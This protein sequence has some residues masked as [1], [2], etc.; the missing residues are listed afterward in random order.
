MVVCDNCFNP[1]CLRTN[2]L[3]VACSCV[4][5]PTGIIRDDLATGATW[6]S[7]IQALPQTSTG[8]SVSLID[9][10]RGHQ[11]AGTTVPALNAAAITLYNGGADLGTGGAWYSAV[12]GTDGGALASMLSLFKHYPQERD[13]IENHLQGLALSATQAATRTQ[14]E[15]ANKY[16][17]AF[18]DKL[19]HQTKELP[20]TATEFEDRRLPKSRLYVLCAKGRMVTKL[21]A[22]QAGA[23][24]GKFDATLG[25]N[26]T[27]FEKL[28]AVTD[29]NMLHNI[30]TDYRAC[31]IQIGKNG[32]TVAWEPFWSSIH[33]VLTASMD[34]SMTHELIYE[35]LVKMDEQRIDPL[36]FM[37]KKWST[38]YTTFML[39]FGSSSRENDQ[40][41]SSYPRGS[42]NDDDNGEVT[43]PGTEP[44]HIK[45]GPV[46][47][48]GVWCGEMR[49]RN[50]AIAFCNKWNERKSCN[51]GVFAG[52]NKGKCAYTHKCR[53][54]MSPDHR[55]VDKHP[56]GH[57]Q[58][59][60]WVC[61]KHP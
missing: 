1:D 58:A 12:D 46:T 14:C 4:E 54:C 20:K 50:G 23:T 59:G 48:Q 41:D 60:E 5:I 37:D 44:T 7:V 29:M 52:R 18:S 39:K 61:P 15:N 25:S 56:T 22:A 35:S 6:G 16:C 9:A 55:M 11:A 36:S 27:S 57:A 26:I 51:R 30:M 33:E 47:S 8:V 42:A 43:R 34:V 40:P 2:N 3:A 10:L 24:A 21:T 45:F 49:T 53:Y 17:V 13:H 31:I 38:F 32:G 19:R 28:R